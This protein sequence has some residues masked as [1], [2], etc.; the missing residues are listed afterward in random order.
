MWADEL[1]FGAFTAIWQVTLMINAAGGA[2]F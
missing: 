1:G 2:S